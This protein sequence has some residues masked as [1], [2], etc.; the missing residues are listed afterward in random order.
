MSENNNRLQEFAAKNKVYLQSDL[1]TVGDNYAVDVSPIVQKNREKLSE[2]KAEASKYNGAYVS[3]P[4]PRFLFPNVTLE[5]PTGYTLLYLQKE[6][7]EVGGPQPRSEISPYD[8]ETQELYENIKAY[9]QK[10]PIDVYPSPL[11]NGKYRIVEGHRRKYV[12]FDSLYGK[13][14]GGPGMWA[15]CKDRTEQEAYEDALILNGK[16]QFTPFETGQYYKAMLEKFPDVYPTLEAIGKKVGVTSGTISH[17]IGAFEEID[18]LKGKIDPSLLTRVKQLPEK[19]IRPIR[20]VPDVSKQ[21]LVAVIAEMG[22][23]S[24]ESDHLAEFVKKNHVVSKSELKAEVERIR[25][26]KEQ[27]KEAN[28]KRILS[29]GE[30]FVKKSER[31]VAHL[32]KCVEAL[33]PWS[34]VKMIYD[35]L[36]LS[37]IKMTDQNMRKLCPFFIDALVKVARGRGFF[38]EVCMIAETPPDFFL[39]NE[40]EQNEQNKNTLYGVPLEKSIERATNFLTDEQRLYFFKVFLGEIER[41]I[42]P[43]DLSSERK[44]ARLLGVSD[45]V[46]YAWKRKS[47]QKNWLNSEVKFAPKERIPSPKNV[48]KMVEQLRKI[49]PFKA[50]L[51]LAQLR[52]E[53]HDTFKLFDGIIQPVET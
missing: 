50:N 24:R 52:T 26:E 31:E 43:D 39:K 32:A 1:Y 28:K 38:D 16:K 45:S 10:D 11:G 21:S 47:E 34:L 13:F 25:K 48:A 49:N 17:I 30:K 3:S 23:S 18:G 20:S 6:A 15:I 29:E 5:V 37:R 22:S 46:V 2:L 4:K 19:V 27:T 53:I 7:I 35:R 41:G 12:C 42:S 36:S 9:G 51:L 8:P 33:Y 14:P 44:I 40:E